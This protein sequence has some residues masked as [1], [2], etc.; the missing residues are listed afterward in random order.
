MRFPLINRNGFEGYT[1]IAID[2]TENCIEALRD[3]EAGKV[4]QCFVEMSACVGS[5]IGG[6]VS[7]Q[8]NAPASVKEYPPGSEAAAENISES[9]D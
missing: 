5:C 6:P 9:A 4:N 2:G 8:H 3:I 7:Y 1:Y